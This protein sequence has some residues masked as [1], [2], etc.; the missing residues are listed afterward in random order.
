[1]SADLLTAAARQFAPSEPQLTLA[2][3]RDQERAR[4]TTVLGFWIYLMTDCVLFAALFATYSVLG[5]EFDGGPRGSEL[6]NLPYVLIETLCLLASS[7]TYGLV[8][9]ELNAKKKDSVI[10]FLLITF[11]LGLSFVGLEVREFI[12]MVGEGAGPDRSAFLSA[13]FTLVG[14]HGLHVPCYAVSTFARCQFSLSVPSCNAGS[15]NQQDSP[16]RPRGQK[17]S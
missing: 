5:R 10:G 11:L 12:R 9:V 6:F 7:F 14:T 4:L 2:E 16:R 17:L 3:E 15:N 8:M 1:M 13:F